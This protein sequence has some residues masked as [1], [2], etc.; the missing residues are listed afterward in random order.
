MHNIRWM[1]QNKFN[2]L[3]FCE[4][5]LLCSNI[6]AFS[7]KLKKQIFSQSFIDDR[8]PPFTFSYIYVHRPT[9]FAKLCNHVGHFYFVETPF[10]EIQFMSQR[11]QTRFCSCWSP[12]IMI[13]T[14][15]MP[16]R[17]PLVSAKPQNCIWPSFCINNLGI[18]KSATWLHLYKKV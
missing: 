16:W 15:C 12:C 4:N 10:K 5:K 8:I 1:Q 6:W 9:V 11:K 3:T 14:F 2:F 13:Q 7:S 17:M 18:F